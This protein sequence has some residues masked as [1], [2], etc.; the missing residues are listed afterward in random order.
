MNRPALHGLLLAGGRSRRMGRDKAELPLPDGTTLRERSIRLLE[1]VVDRVF[2]STA[3]D[4]PR[5]GDPSSLPDL[6]PGRGPLAGLEAAFHHGPDR[7]WLVLAC[8]LPLLDAETLAALTAA[9]DPARAATAFA[10]RFD[11]RP[12]P[13]CA[14]YEPSA[15]PALQE[16]L[17]GDKRCARRFLESLDPLLIPLPNRHALDNCNRPEDLA[18][19]T[20]LA[21][22]GPVSKRVTIEYFAQLRDQ[23]GRQCEARETTAAT[24]AGLWEE[25]RM[26]HQFPLDL[27]AVRTAVD[28]EIVP[29]TTAIH[30][31]DRVAFLPPAP[32]G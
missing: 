10:S 3:P 13:L 9:R 16:F 20:A 1:E 7:A 23:A 15:V 17:A 26:S 28:D 32:G 31:G 6:A 27:D 18:E 14:I 30:D 5:A 29:W 2:L 21:A 4:D 22:T 24:A 19:A 25:V 8:D 11:G 12:E